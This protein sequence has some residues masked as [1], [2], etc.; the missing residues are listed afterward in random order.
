[1]PPASSLKNLIYSAGKTQAHSHWAKGSWKSLK[2]RVFV[3]N[4]WNWESLKLKIFEIENLWYWKSLKLKIFK[5]LWNWKSLK[6]II[7]EIKIFEIE[8]LWNWDSGHQTL[9]APPLVDQSV[10]K[11]WR[12]LRMSRGGL[13]KPILKNICKWS[14]N[15]SHK[16]MI[17]VSK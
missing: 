12:W 5:N 2:L 11:G 15:S 8:N 7:F 1:M 9:V 13:K 6:L 3:Q 14:E 17:M 4:L 16:Q 10:E